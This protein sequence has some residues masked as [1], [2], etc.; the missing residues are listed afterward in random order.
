MRRKGVEKKSET[1]QKQLNK[2]FKR[3]QGK[4]QQQQADKKDTKRG[5]VREER[6]RGGGEHALAIWQAWQL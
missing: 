4:R 3:Q 2:I 6:E 5:R 1:G